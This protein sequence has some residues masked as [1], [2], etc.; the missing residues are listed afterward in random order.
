MIVVMGIKLLF[1]EVIVKKGVAD[2]DDDDDE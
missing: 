1:L 2:G